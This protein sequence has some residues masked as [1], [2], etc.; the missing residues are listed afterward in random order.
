MI[1]AILLDDE[2]IILNELASLLETDERVEIIGTYTDPL[3]LLQ[4][5]PM[6]KP[7]CIFLDIEMPGMSGIE[8]AE[9]LG[10]DNIAAEIVFI[11]AYNH[12][13]AQ[14][15][16]VSAIDYLLKP[17]R[18]ERIRKAVDKLVKLASQK[19]QP[20][21]GRWAI[22]SF[23]PF[24]VKHGQMSIKWARS[25]SRELLAYFLQ[26]EGRWLSKYKL[27]DDQ[28]GHY[29]PER[30][31]AYLQTSLYAMRKNLKAAGCTE[32]KIEY[33]NDRY[34]LRV[35]DADWDLRTFES[36][37]RQFDQTASDEA[38]GQALAVYRGEY[39]EGEDWLWS[40]ITRETY[41]RQVHQLKKAAK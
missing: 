4:E 24:E 14:A 40:D 35:L 33:A 20:L 11:T 32:L 13:A 9:Q 27:C 2:P 25:K 7:D 6:L 41:R 10:A 21:H 38:R 36:A 3:Q 17:I 5:I 18:P 34:I 23:G 15:F 22:H 8:L 28:W 26:H 16:D 30:A 29:E 19:P 1:R 31:L 37:L 39:L 12:Y